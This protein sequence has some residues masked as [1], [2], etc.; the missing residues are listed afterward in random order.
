MRSILATS[1]LVLGAL[2]A[3]GACSNA[4]APPLPSAGTDEA[5]PRRGGTLQLASFGD[6]SA[7]DPAV[8]TDALSQQPIEL[9]FAGLVD[10]DPSG[11][12]VPDLAERF[13]VA[14][15][16]REIHFFLRPG[17]RFHDGEPLEATDV[18]R[19]IERALH[20]DCPAPF[21]SFYDRIEGFAEYRKGERPHLDG[22]RIDGALAVTVRLREPDATFLPAFAM[23][24]LRPVCKSGGATYDPD[25]EPCGAGPFKL[26]RGGWDRGRSLRVV[27][28][29]A[30]HR[31]GEPL[32]DAVEWSFGMNGVTQRFKLEAGE[33]D[34]THDLSLGDGMRFKRDPRWGPLVVQEEARSI[35]GEG[36]NVEL[37]PF[38]NVEI[39]R[40]VA[41]AIDREQYRM[42]RTPNMEVLERV[43]S[44]A[45]APDDP[46][47]PGQHHDLAAALDHMARAGYPYDPKTGTGGWPAP[48][49]YVVYKQGLWELT[50][51]LLQQQLARIG[52]RIELRIVSYPTYLA[53][54]R[55]RGMAAFAP[56]GWQAD[57]PDRGDFFDPL[58]ASSAIDD[59]STNNTSFY[60]NP[61]LDELLVRARRELDAKARARMYDEADAIVCRDAPW[62][63]TY[64]YRGFG[65]S[66]P[67]VR[68]TKPHLV[69]SGDY[70]RTW[71]DRA[72]DG[73]K[74]HAGVLGG[75]DGVLG[76][77]R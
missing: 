77:L 16:G 37:P 18:K 51:Q 21:A 32:L 40:A 65:V 31:P 60:S 2:G 19:S 28:H 50:A 63:F 56:E 9:L 62:A 12:V 27:R 70:R 20:P 24:P 68:G 73:L 13:E 26:A 59:E 41:A 55:R 61:T 39:R 49:P 54:A 74:A 43:L 25:W 53:L 52:L 6:V 10:F 8:A 1:A 72:G 7:L 14:G 76:G 66:Q 42:L 36:M 71:L 58:F 11:N 45:F 47:F 57:Y 38:D 23:Q 46:T 67:Y 33:L 17:L 5:T 35:N 30:Y 34:L 69:W 29:D 22:V 15:D 4:P 44:R 48:I 3:L 64:A 75:R